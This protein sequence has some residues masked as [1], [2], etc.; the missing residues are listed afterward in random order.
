VLGPREDG[1]FD[2][3]V[4]MKMGPMSMGYKGSVAIAEQD[5]EARRAV[6]SAKGAEQRGQ[7]NAQAT[8]T[9]TVTDL[10]ADGTQVKVSSDILVTGRVAQMGRGIMQDVATRMMGEMARCIE[11]T[12]AAGTAP[13]A[14][15]PAG[16]AGEPPSA[17]GATEPPAAGASPETGEPAPVTPASVAQPYAPSQPASPGPRPAPPA[18]A[19]PIKGGRLFLA[20]IWGRIRSLVRRERG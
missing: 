3:K 16:G 1:G 5:D 2:A 18:Q 10:G 9:M 14:E 19:A 17:A 15:E 4:S 8:M 20:V 11:A 13:A 7:G 12:I 6:M